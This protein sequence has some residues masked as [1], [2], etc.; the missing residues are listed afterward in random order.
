MDI[1]DIILVIQWRATCKLSTVWQRFGHAIR[2][3]ALQGLALLF[4]E[5]EYFDDVR[6]EKWKRQQNK[7]RKADTPQNQQAAK[8]QVIEEGTV[9]VPPPTKAQSTEPE[10]MTDAGVSGLSPADTLGNVSVSDTQ[11][12]ELIKPNLDVVSKQKKQRELDPAMDWLINAHLRG[13]GCHRKVFDLHFDNV[14]A[15]VGE[16]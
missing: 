10:G 8:Q 4:A 15:L 5:K 16:S 7:K 1:P 9:P 13:I 14:S 3:C 2:D 6:E 12:K 11:L